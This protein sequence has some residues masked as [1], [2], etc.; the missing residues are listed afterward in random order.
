MVCLASLFLA[1]KKT[2]S[3]ISVNFYFIS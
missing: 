3:R 1:H 2:E